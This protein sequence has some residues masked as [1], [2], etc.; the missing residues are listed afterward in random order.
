MVILD[1]KMSYK[2]LEAFKIQD[3][4]GK[5]LNGKDETTNKKEDTYVGGELENRGKSLASELERFKR[6]AFTNDKGSE[7]NGQILKG[8]EE[9]RDEVIIR[10]QI[11]FKYIISSLRETCFVV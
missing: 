1:I 6:N 5:R 3:K 4:E 11:Y 2:P 10:H 9:R 7:F 8:D